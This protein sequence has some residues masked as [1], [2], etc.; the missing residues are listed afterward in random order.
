MN[1]RRVVFALA[2]AL[3]LPPVGP[4]A[5]AAQDTPLFSVGG[6]IA[7][8]S[9]ASADTHDRGFDIA[10]SGAFPIS[11]RIE[12]EVTALYA[13][14]SPKTAFALEGFGIDPSGFE[15]GGGFVDGGLR[16][17]GG[18]TVGARVLLMPRDRRLVPS[19]SGGVGWA[20]S[21]VS[22]I[23]VL[24]LGRREGADGF[25]ENSPSVTFGGTLDVRIREG[26]GVFGA[27]RYLRVF[28]DPEPTVFLPLTLGLTLR[29]EQR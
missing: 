21:G 20:G 3:C 8:P 27:L 24:Y 23:T 1:A 10:A 28:T 17:V 26:V 6:G 16:W 11:S 4:R 19:V 5:A 29:L 7:A 25:S 22:D 18:V 12:V 14:L 9:G 2:A 13:R 15:L